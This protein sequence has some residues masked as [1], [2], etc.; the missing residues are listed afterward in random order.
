MIHDGFERDGIAIFIEYIGSQCRIRRGHS[1]TA[2]IGCGVHI[3]VV[4]FTRI[5]EKKPP[6]FSHCKKKR[7]EKELRYFL[8]R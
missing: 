6:S 1:P 5:A 3:V 2:V 8:E 7:K 4:V